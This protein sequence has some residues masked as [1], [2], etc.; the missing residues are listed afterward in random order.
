MSPFRS[1]D[2]ANALSLALTFSFV[3]A[4]VY[5]PLAASLFSRSYLTDGF[6]VS[7]KDTLFNSH[8]LCFYVDALFTA[9]LGLLCWRH[10]ATASMARVRENYLGVLGHGFGHLGL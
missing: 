5:K 4:M 10:Q 9:A 8:A 3:G 6:C 2:A 1:G 7:F